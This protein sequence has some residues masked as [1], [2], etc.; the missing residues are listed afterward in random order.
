M[1][2]A[3]QRDRRRQNFRPAEITG[4]L[5]DAASAEGAASIAKAEPSIDILVNNLGIYESKAF[6]DITDADWSHMFNVNVMS[7][8]RL[9][10]TYLPGMVERKLALR[11]VS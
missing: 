6:S 11:Q 8:V 10:R 7:G 4:I 2:L 5:A 3:R 1:A 9:S